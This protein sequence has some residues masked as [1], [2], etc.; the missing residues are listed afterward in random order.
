MAPGLLVE[1]DLEVKVDRVLHISAG[2]NDRLVRIRVEVVFVDRVKVEDVVH[3]R[4]GL[5]VEDIP[6]KAGVP[7]RFG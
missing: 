3:I 2:L 6:G 1:I 5:E 4:D 7:P